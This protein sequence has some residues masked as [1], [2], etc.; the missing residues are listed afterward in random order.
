MTDVYGSK[1][2]RYA[3]QDSVISYI[4]SRIDPI[5]TNPIYEIED[6]GFRFYPSGI[7]RARLSYVRKPPR[8]YWAYTLD[9]NGLPIQDLANSEDPIWY[10]IDCMDIIARALRIISVNLQDVNVAQY[11]NEL[12]MNGQ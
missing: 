2:I 11:A 6:N 3:S 1:S 12:K 9:G 10:D 4:N 5:A 8:I 7:G